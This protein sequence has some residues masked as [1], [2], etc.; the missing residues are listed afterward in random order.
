M[1]P[2][3]IPAWMSCSIDHHS[4]GVMHF[5]RV[6][7]APHRKSSSFTRVYSPAWWRS[8]SWSTL[9]SGKSP[10]LKYIMNG[11]R[12]SEWIFMT[13]GDSV[14]FSLGGGV[15]W[16]DSAILVA[17]AKALEMLGSWNSYR[18][19][20]V[21]TKARLELSLANSSATSFFPRN[22][23]KYSRPLKLFSNL[24]SSW[25]YNI[26]LSSKHDNSLLARLTT[27]SKSPRTLRRR[28]LSAMVILRPWSNAS[29]SAALLDTRKCICKTYL[30]LS[31]LGDVTRIPTPMPWSYKDPSKLMVQYSSSLSLGGVCISVHSATKSLKAWALIAILGL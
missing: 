29:Y 9:S 2:P 13:S 19:T 26:I 30:K 21:G 10:V 31:P 27:S 4:F 12:Q 11:V 6:P 18:K 28:M 23:Y 25:Q 14:I 17:F 8:C 24:R 1:W 3:Q 22:I 7:L 5:I 15:S 20:L 16:D